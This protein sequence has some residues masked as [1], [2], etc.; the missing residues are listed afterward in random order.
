MGGDEPEQLAP[1]P[2]EDMV[3]AARAFTSYFQVR[4]LTDTEQWS[5]S[6]TVQDNSRSAASTGLNYKKKEQPILKLKVVCHDEGVILRWMA[7]QIS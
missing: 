5:L 7:I 4:V 3:A 6:C 2:S 1:E